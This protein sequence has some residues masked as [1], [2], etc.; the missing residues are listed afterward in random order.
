VLGLCLLAGCTD[1]KFDHAGDASCADCQVSKSTD[2]ELPLVK[3]ASSGRV[4]DA[5]GVDLSAAMLGTYAVHTRFYGHELSTGLVSVQHELILL[6]QITRGPSGLRMH[7]TTCQDSGALV[8]G[9]GL[10]ND[11]RVKYPEHLPQRDY[12]LVIEG[13]S[14]HTTGDAMLIGFQ[15]TVPGCTEGATLA[16]DHPWLNGTCSCMSQATLPSDPADCRVIDSDADDKPGMTVEA[17]GLVSGTSSVRIRDTSQYALGTIDPVARRHRASFDKKEDILELVCAGKC[18]V[19]LARWCA[20][21]L[22]P[23]SFEPLQGASSS[24]ADVL[25]RV[26]NNELF[27]GEKL[28]GSFPTGC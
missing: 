17:S 6:A 2:G 25:R 27:S 16:S 11:V 12:D 4:M 22:Q 20:L 7:M 19:Y 15:E 9:V 1:P 13:T 10:G 26:E 14:F 8:T 23:V 28:D 21:P 3:D 5:S 18:P 24:C